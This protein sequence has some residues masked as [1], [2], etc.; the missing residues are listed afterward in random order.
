MAAAGAGAVSGSH[1]VKGLS[2]WTE[3]VGGGGGEKSRHPIA[4]Y[5]SQAVVAGRK[6]KS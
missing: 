6:S 5:H 3:T 4:T 1:P 2:V